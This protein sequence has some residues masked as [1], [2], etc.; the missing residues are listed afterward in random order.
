MGPLAAVIPA[1]TAIGGLVGAG[2]SLISA[3]RKPPSASTPS[4]KPSTPGALSTKEG[5]Q[6][7]TG[8]KQSLINTS[9]SG[10]LDTAESTR[11]RL[12]GS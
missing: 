2:S 1:I 8:Q 10:V 7:T 6:L 9:P 4:I 12:L 11:A 3:F 5:K